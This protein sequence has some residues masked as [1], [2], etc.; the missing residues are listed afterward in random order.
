MRRPRVHAHTCARTCT[1]TCALT[2]A[3]PR[4]PYLCA[5][6]CAVALALWYVRIAIAV[7]CRP[8]QAAAAVP[9]R[10]RRPEHAARG[11]DG[12]A[13]LPAVVRRSIR[14]C[15][16]MHASAR[17]RRWNVRW[18]AYARAR[19]R[20]SVGQISAAAIPSAHALPLVTRWRIMRRCDARSTVSRPSLGTAWRGVA[21]S[22]SCFSSSTRPFR[23]HWRRRA[24][25]SA[26][27]C[28][29][30]EPPARPV[31]DACRHQP[32]EYT[33]PVCAASRRCRCCSARRRSPRS[34]AIAPAARMCAAAARPSRRC[35]A[36]RA[37][38]CGYLRRT[39][40]CAHSLSKT[41]PE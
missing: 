40:C 29:Q 27:R 14:A 30:R 35:D 36:C 3:L 16:R 28:A 32:C 25:T 1:P 23:S 34:C 37:A 8:P 26:R 17:E 10:G 22:C 24:R 31:A 4:V 19:P 7:R 41:R 15:A 9:A 5:H 6:T 33:R 2:R 11:R 39:P 13:S 18:C 21:A 20:R 38:C 12:S